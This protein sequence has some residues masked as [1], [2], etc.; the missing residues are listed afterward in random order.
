[1]HRIIKDREMGLTNR[2]RRKALLQLGLLG[3][4]ATL[5]DMPALTST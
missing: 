1:M 2:D 3:C 4:A 5:L